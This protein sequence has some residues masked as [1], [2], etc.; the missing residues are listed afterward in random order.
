MRYPAIP[1]K[2]RCDRHCD[3]ANAI[4][5]RAIGGSSGW[6]TKQKW[7]PLRFCGISGPESPETPVN[8]GEKKR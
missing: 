1:E 7:R 5:Y 4:P 2:H 8:G 6:A 3:Y